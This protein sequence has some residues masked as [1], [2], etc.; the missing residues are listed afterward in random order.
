[1]RHNIRLG[2]IAVFL[3]V[4]AVVVATLAVL[5]TSTAN[6]DKVMAERFADVTKA[7]YELEAR[8]QLF[9]QKYDEQVRSGSVDPG[10]LGAE[11]SGSGE[12]KE[13]KGKGYILEVGV[14][15]AGPDGKYRVTGWKLKKQWNAD[16]PYSNVWKGE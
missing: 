8:G 14:S 16:D 12:V 4:V 1:M 10:K 9:I 3:T 15:S 5:S 6:A 13:I 7:R 2:P 11:K